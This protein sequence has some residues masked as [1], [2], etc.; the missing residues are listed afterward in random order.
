MTTLVRM[1]VEPERV[2]GLPR[3]CRWPSL[4]N[5]ARMTLLTAAVSQLAFSLLVM[6]GVI[7]VG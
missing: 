5:G 2:G 4:K 7:H 1:M 3:G 6:A